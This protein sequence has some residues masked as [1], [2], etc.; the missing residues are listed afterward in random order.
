[1]TAR[2]GDGDIV[3][4][5]TYFGDFLPALSKAC[6]SDRKVWAF[7]PNNENFRCANITL[8]INDIHNVELM[9][10]GLGERVETLTMGTV[11][12][13][14]E[15][16]GGGSRVVSQPSDSSKGLQSVEIFPIDNV[17]PQDRHVSIVQLDVE[18]YEEKALRGAIKTIR[19]CLPILILEDWPGSNLVESKWFSEN[20]SPLRYTAVDQIHG[21][22]VLNPNKQR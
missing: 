6:A 13:N 16:L 1:M 5:G 22:I 12:A 21:N 2:C 7:E 4:A 17:V 11:D 20:L 14:G 18:G 3:H 19:R 10:A 15:A 8:L 9:N